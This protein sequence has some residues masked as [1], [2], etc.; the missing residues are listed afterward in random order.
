MSIRTD[1]LIDRR[2]HDVLVF[3]SLSAFTAAIPARW[4]SAEVG[5]GCPW[6]T[7]QF[8]ACH[9]AAWLP[10]TGELFIVR[11]GPETLGGDV[12]VL[13]HVPDADILEGMLDGWQEAC[14]GFDSIRWLRGRVA[15][16][17]PLKR[18]D[19]WGLRGPTRQRSIRDPRQ[20]R[21]GD[22]R[23]GFAKPG[24]PWTAP[25]ERGRTPLLSRPDRLVPASP[26]A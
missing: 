22:E 2:V 5:F 15:T 8:G 10:A 25:N 4:G 24:S 7:A 13:A 17:H 21:R 6:R 11:L 1:H 3:P 9:R 23:T 18:R 12:E 20:R 16:A 19:G 14:G 26:A